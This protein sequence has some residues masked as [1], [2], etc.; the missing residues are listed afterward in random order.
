MTRRPRY[1]SK[2]EVISSIL[3]STQSYTGAT[4]AQIQY[5][6]YVS[7]K[8]LKDYLTLLIQH[9]Q[10]EFEREE[11]MFRITESGINALHV[12]DEMDKLLALQL[13]EHSLK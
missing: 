10:I 4:T 3:K 1:R 8:K 6:T 7:Y 12:F 13:T 9:K 5:E 11:M 2:P